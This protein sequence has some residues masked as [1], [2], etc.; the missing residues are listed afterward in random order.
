[1]PSFSK[2]AIEEADAP[3]SVIDLCIPLGVLHKFAQDLGFG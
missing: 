1:M 3:V 2:G